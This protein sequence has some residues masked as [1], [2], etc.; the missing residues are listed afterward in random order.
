MNLYLSDKIKVLSLVSILIVLCIHSGFHAYEIE[1]MRLNEYVQGAISEMIGRCAVPLFYI[2]SGYLFFYEI[3]NGLHSIFEKQKKRMR[4]LLIPYII[5]SV[6]FVFFCVLVTIVPGTAQFINSSI[7]PLFENN[8]GNIFYNIFYDAGTGMPIA[9]QLWFLRDL[10]LLVILSPIWYLLYKYLR[11]YWVIGVFALNYLS[12]NH[13]P[14][15]P[16]FWFGLG[17]ALVS[18]NIFNWNIK[19][20]KISILLVTFLILCTLQLFYSQLIIWDYIK[21][22]I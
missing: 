9:A 13:F 17:G 19:S 5:A 7:L 20:Y 16:L 3:P 2:I 11:W 22:P 14:V 12:L 18:T 10:I 4:T 1:G 21:I 6:F 8:L 15:Y